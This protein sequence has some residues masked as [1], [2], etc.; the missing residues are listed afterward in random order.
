MKKIVVLVISI[1]TLT[2]AKKLLV[3]EQFLTIQSAVITVKNNDTVSVNFGKV[4]GQRTIVT[5]SRMFNKDITFEVRGEG[6]EELMRMIADVFNL[7]KTMKSHQN[8]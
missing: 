4:N 5:T 8:A 3:P 1:F 7:P 6:K 2:Q